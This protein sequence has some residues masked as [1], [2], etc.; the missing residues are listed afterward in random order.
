[1]RIDA[2]TPTWFNHIEVAISAATSAP[3]SELPSTRGGSDRECSV[4]KPAA[5]FSAGVAV[6]T[7]RSRD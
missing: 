7:Q 2:S 6:Y 5:W 1:M 3:D 4:V